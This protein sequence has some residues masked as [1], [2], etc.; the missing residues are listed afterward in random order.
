MCKSSW[1]GR[2]LVEPGVDGCGSGAVR[3][4]A[5]VDVEAAEQEIVRRLVGR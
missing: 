5:D 4:A 3:I 1:R 2:I